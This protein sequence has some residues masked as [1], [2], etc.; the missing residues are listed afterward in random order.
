VNKWIISEAQLAVVAAS[1]AIDEYRFDLASATIYNFIWNI[2]CDWYLEF[3]KP[4]LSGDNQKDKDETR[5]ATAWVLEIA[6]RVL[7]PFMPFI[8]EELWEQVTGSGEMLMAQK[9][10]AFGKKVVD[11]DAK[12]EIDWVIRLIST[13]RTIRAE[14][15]VPA[16]AQV[17]L[18]LK[19]MSKEN[20]TRL[21]LHQ[22]LIMRLARLGGITHVNTVP[23]GSAQAI[24]DETTLILPLA[25]VID[26]DKER[27][28][29][30]KEIEKQRAEI[31]K[32]ESKLANENFVSNAPPE[33]V[34]E[35]RVRKAEAEAMLAKLQSARDALAA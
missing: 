4:I 19:D 6:L 24:V 5:A 16:A 9:W 35:H 18:Q 22:P 15:N 32:I 2:F 8:T 3:T 26:L 17:Q 20:R 14:L 27:A 28:R 12:D 34:E 30:D 21:E 31:K 29:I 7:H 33:V 11:E 25:D 23:K 13:V 1:V 10:P